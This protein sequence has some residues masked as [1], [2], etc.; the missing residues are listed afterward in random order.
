MNKVALQQNVLGKMLKIGTG[1]VG[2]DEDD[3][4]ITHQGYKVYLNGKHKLPNETEFNQRMI[5]GEITHPY[6]MPGMSSYPGVIKYDCL[7]GHES[8]A[9]IAEV[10][11]DDIEDEPAIDIVAMSLRSDNPYEMDEEEDLPFL[12]SEMLIL[13]FD[14]LFSFYKS[15]EDLEPEGWIIKDKSIQNVIKEYFE[16]K[17]LNKS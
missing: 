2:K 9:I 12:L 11:I 1:F 16:R 8:Y 4:V 7:I 5:I 15:F 3:P 14:N 13:H 10:K 6:I 17:N